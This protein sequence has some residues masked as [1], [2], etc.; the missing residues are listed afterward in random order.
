MLSVAKM[1]SSVPATMKALVKEKESESYIYKEIPVPDPQEDEVLIRVDCVAICGSDINLYKWNDIAR[2]IASIPFVPG[3]ECA[4]TVVKCG[5]KASLPLGS[6]VGVENHFFCGS[7]YQCKFDNPAICRNMGQFGHG[8]LTQHGGCSEYSIVQQKY[9]YQLKRDLTPEEIAMLEPLGVSHN[10]IEKLEVK[11]EEVLVIGCGPVGLLAQAVAKALGAKRVIGA[12][13]D[14]TRLELAKKMGADI[15]VNTMK[16]NLKEFVMK[17]TDGLGI[18][19]ICECSGAPTMVNSS[20]GMLRKGGHIVMVGLPKE[21][22]HVENVLQDVVF[23]SLTLK[24]VH[25]RQIYHTWSEVENLVA[26]KKIDVNKIIS[27]KFQMSHF[28]EAF[29]ALFSGKA[30]KIVIYPSA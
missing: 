3:H 22:L 11:D 20:F 24:T 8:K 4:G 15:I 2:V 12:D 16:E 14:E 26:D 9:L 18:G 7:C 28:E 10:A 21:P 17:H 6:K 25:G 30:C 19:R 29:S 27:H 5:P 1:S 23:K 13:I